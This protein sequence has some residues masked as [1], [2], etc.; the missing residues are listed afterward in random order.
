MTRRSGFV[1]LAIAIAIACCC[2]GLIGYH[3][4]SRRQVAAPAPVVV[5]TEPA[6]SEA[7]PPAPPRV[8]TIIDLP[9]DPVL[10]RRGATLAP[11]AISVALPITLAA[12]A[13][14]VQS[15]A[16]FVTSPL[17]SS[18]G[19]FMGK[20]PEA[21]EGADVADP[22]A[23]SEGIAMALDADSAGSDD[24]GGSST[25]D[26]AQQTVVTDLN[27]TQLDVSVGGSNAP[28]QLKEAIIRVVLQEKISEL[29]IRNG[30]SQDSS[31]SV[32]AAAK[33]AYNVQSLPPGSVA[34]AVGA[35]DT[36]GAYRVTQLAIYENKEYVGA[37][38]LA[39]SGGYGEG[40]QP[41]V[42][43]GVLDDGSKDIDI[44]VHYNLADGLYSAGLRNNVPE[45]VIR[46][47]IRLLGK[48]TDLK[49]P[50]SPEEN[51]R[52]LYARDFRGKSKLS[53]K[54]IYFGLTGPGGAVDCYSFQSADGSFR[55]FD[56]K[57]GGGG[58]GGGAAAPAGGG[59]G[60]T[61]SSA[62]AGA[63]FPPIK[64]APVTSLF[65]MRFHPILHITR[66]HAGIDFGAAVGSTV[67][68]VAD[69]KVE[70]AGPVSGFGNHV[71]IQHK[72]FETSYSHLS[73]IL[74][75][76]GGTVVSGQTIGLSGNTGL[77]T[78]PHLHFEYYLDRAAV[79]PLPHMSGEVAGAAIAA[80]GGGT[81]A[82]GPSEQET[83]AFTSEKTLVDA[84]LQTASN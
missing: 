6:P 79:D 53:G 30:F 77:S 52:A 12:N 65:G 18:D 44:G 58:G 78:G 20:F 7:V 9:G 69:G 32:E 25:P 43:T 5:S 57:S 37:I 49:A 1:L 36:S 24:D 74:V 60:A 61:A 82:S 34:I 41:S 23:V 35:L 27:S 17:V 76:V 51:L 10:V 46:E 59:V 47:A 15:A 19:G 4:L 29:L 63:I 48:L 31:L 80:N 22:T 67:R 54:V 33:S 13:P 11:R 42:P 38:A 26:A 28:P 84:A 66:L 50:L 73:E 70:I 75:S 64:G 83:A 45:P 81:V 3:I 14:K 39:E 68:A 72:G 62:S 71:R 8:S 55:C 56:P 40:A 16:Y 21:A 2:A